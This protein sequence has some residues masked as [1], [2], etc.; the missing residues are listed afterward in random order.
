MFANTD[1][2][3]SARSAQL[4]S[5]LVYRHDCTNHL[6]FTPKT[7]GKGRD[8][9][10]HPPRT[11]QQQQQQQKYKL[12]SVMGAG[13]SRSS[14][15]LR[16]AFV[17]VSAGCFLFKVSARTSLP[18]SSSPSPLSVVAATAEASPRLGFASP[19]KTRERGVRRRIN[20]RAAPPPSSRA[21]PAVASATTPRQVALA[22]ARAA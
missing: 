19:E 13:L 17:S 4:I 14:L 2:H 11:Q 21:G 7:G 5:T 16:G 10:S 20:D 1:E 12:T 8:Y 6:S 9:R 18:P 22:D 3:E 15:L